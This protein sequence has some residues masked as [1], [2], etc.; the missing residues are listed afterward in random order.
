M[1]M[2]TTPFGVALVGV[3]SS[4][5]GGLIG[6]AGQ[7]LTRSHPAHEVSRQW[8]EFANETKKRLD[9]AEARLDVQGKELRELGEINGLLRRM[10]RRAVSALEWFVQGAQTQPPEDIPALILE[11]REHTGKENK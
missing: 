3:I 2:L 9:E 11:A 8:K 5:L 4:V 7:A 6:L 1:D 10:L